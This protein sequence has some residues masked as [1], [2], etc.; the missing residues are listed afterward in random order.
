MTE[1]NRQVGVPIATIVKILLVGA[2]VWALLKL[3]TLI[4]VVLA[5]VVIAIACEPVVARLERRWLP[6]WLASA[7]VVVA[8]ATAVVLFFMGTGSSLVNQGR[9]VLENLLKFR[10]TLANSLPAP[11]AGVVRGG[12]TL[13]SDA[14][15]I[16]EY[17]VETGRIIAAA[18]LGALVVAIL[19]LYLLIEGRTTWAWLVAYVPARNRARVQETAEAAREAVLHYVVANV[20]TSIFAA[21]VV[22]IGLAILKVP[23]ALLLAALAGICDFVPVLG[24][25][26]SSVPAVL[27]ALTVSVPTALLVGALYISYH[28]VENYFIAPR[29]YGDRLRLS[30]LAVLLAFAVGAELFGVIGALL[31]LPIAAMYPCVED[32][33]LRDYLGRDAVERHR[34]IERKGA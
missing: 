23:A 6:R 11:L 9:E 31:A 21:V 17:A 27:L 28:A 15:L 25:I 13:N 22:Y 1:Q 2:A 7:L 3:A 4:A 26:V 24:F 14:Q 30:N 34:R 12:G 18:L 5:S 33:W 10:Q 16:A 19:T 29:V 8:I 20:L 32:I